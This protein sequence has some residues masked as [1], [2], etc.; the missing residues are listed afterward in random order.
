VSAAPSVI[1]APA[2]AADRMNPFPGLRPF[3]EDEE[4]LFFGRESQ[5]DAMVD[6]LAAT[7][8]LTVVGTSG[9]GKSSLVNCG[10]RP[11]LHRGLMASAGTTWRM[12][13]FRPGTDPIRALAGA[14]ASEGVLFGDDRA[15]GPTQAEIVDTTL[16]MSK[17]GLVDVFEQ[18]RLAEDVNL[19]VVVDQFEELFRY[20]QLPAGEQDNAYGVSEAAAA[21]V[22]LLLEAREAASQPIHIV[23]TMRSDFLGECAQFPGLAE[24]INDGQY[25][26][27]RMTRDER[28][29]AIAGPIGVGGSEVEPVLLTRLLNDVGDNPDQLSILQHALNRTWACWQEQGGEGPLGMAQYE[30][31]GTMAHALDR[32][33][34][35]AY[36]ELETP[37]QREICE[38]IFKALTDKATDPRGVRRPTTV[39]TLCESTGASQAEVEGVIDVF[40]EPSR[41]FLMPPDGEALAPETMVDISHESLM[42]VWQ[43]L[44]AWADEEAQSARI[45]RRLA[46]DAQRHDEGETGLLHDPELQFAL[47]WRGRNDPNESWA[48]R[49]HPGF[50]PAMQFLAASERAARVRRGLV[51]AGVVVL[52]VLLVVFGVL[53]FLAWQS[54]NDARSQRRDAETASKAATLLALTGT[55]DDRTV[56]PLDT[57]LL[58]G[59]AAYRTKPSYVSRRSVVLSREQAAN[60]PLGLILRTHGRISALAV[61]PDGSTAATADRLGHVRRWDLRAHRP[62]GP[63][64]EVVNAGSHTTTNH[65]SVAFSPDG[66]DLAEGTDARLTLWDSKRHGVSLRD[67]VDHIDGEVR[68]V[69]FSPDGKDLAAAGFDGHV[70]LWDVKTHRLLARL[71][72]RQELRPVNSLAFSPD[73][74]TIASAG[75]DGLI[76]IWNAGTGRLRVSP[77]RAATSGVT[78]LAFDRNGTLAS[79]TRAG[80]I[81]FWDVNGRKVASPLARQKQ[82]ILDLALSPDG[83]RIAGASDDGSVHVWDRRTGDV[84]FTSPPSGSATSRTVDF[85]SAGRLVSAST[86]GSITVWSE[87][88]SPLGA[89]LPGRVSIPAVRAGSPDYT[90]LP[91]LAVSPDGTTLVAGGDTGLHVW[92]A[93]TGKQ[94]AVAGAGGGGEATAL[95]FSPDGK[96][97]AEAAGGDLYLWQAKDLPRLVPVAAAAHIG[98]NVDTLAFGPDGLLALGDTN[99]RVHVWDTPAPGSRPQPVGVGS[100]IRNPAGER[101]V[102][103]VAFNPQGTMLASGGWDG[104]LRLWRIRNARDTKPIGAPGDMKARGGIRSVAFSPDGRVVAVGSSDGTVS[105]WNAAKRKEIRETTPGSES[106]E[107]VA[108]AANGQVLVT[109][110]DDGTVRLWDTGTLLPLGPPLRRRS[111]AIKRLVVS[112]DASVLATAGDDRTVRSWAGVLWPN[113][114]A[115]TARI[116]GLVSGGITNAEWRTIL[117][118]VSTIAAKEPRPEI[119]HAR[120]R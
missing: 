17:L 76:R 3:R 71:D 87:H 78:A 77:L 115:L 10:L 120:T 81:D 104:T 65:P 102:Y 89:A 56:T 16:R 21:F 34:E 23:L 95:A 53:G 32:H 61:S 97:L 47:N 24:A 82:A 49:Y 99:G 22:N 103:S 67:P 75:D 74:R 6:K 84:L 30:A 18:A 42:R 33:A 98:A 66:R 62:V 86:D 51:G 64:L 1:D 38:R 100:D 19:L 83:A 54:R 91:V 101:L 70:R 90:I 9:S 72:R 113:V 109:T 43:R 7:R 26:V 55:A 117:R 14:L 41:S 88:A 92:N 106:V 110:G 93:E 116:C 94:L 20:R 59:L 46:D 96:L 37:R 69:A 52:I 25:L 85:D 114:D 35:Q 40:R 2:G 79:A 12:A 68:T 15:S 105:L 29:S 58:L 107:S 36:A 45:Y 80:A 27:P 50:A 108:F 48:A 39:R 44:N 4:H 118:R 63:T 31:V 60:Q 112:P 11:A 28:R 5:V 119:C 57:A 73:G 8:F 13:Q 111:G